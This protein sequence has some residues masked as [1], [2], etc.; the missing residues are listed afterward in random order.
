LGD[1]TWLKTGW[2]N[3]FYDGGFTNEVEA[4]GS[5]YV[6]PLVGARVLPGMLTGDLVLS[7]GDLPGPNTTTF[8]I[9]TLNA[10][11]AVGANT[12]T[13]KPGFKPGGALKGTFLHPT[14]GNTA[15][16]GAVLQD[17]NYARGYFQPANKAVVQR[18]RVTLDPTP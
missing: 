6:T 9:S 18:G 13:A 4:I 3:G 5:L 10:F 8:S 7:T 1:F 14:H 17:Y 15:I 11:T 2:T 16:W 12:Y